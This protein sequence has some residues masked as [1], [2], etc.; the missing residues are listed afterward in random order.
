[1]LKEEDYRQYE[2]DS[3][4]A[5]TLPKYFLSKWGYFEA[6]A[7]SLTDIELNNAKKL[8]ATLGHLTE[9]ERI[10]LGNKYR[11]IYEKKHKNSRNYKTDKIVAKEHGMTKKEYV[12]L[13]RGIEHKFFY[14]L[15]NYEDKKITH[16]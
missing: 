14:Y 1:M 9:E 2:S 12:Q 5:L 6:N 7:T 15:Q 16:L 8:Y 11:S 10:F 4:R 3:K 13:R